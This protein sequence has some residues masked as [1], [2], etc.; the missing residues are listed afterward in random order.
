[1]L[2]DD[3]DI[4][5]AREPNVSRSPVICRWV[6]YAGLAICLAT[7]CLLFLSLRWYLTYHGPTFSFGID[8]GHFYFRYGFAA[9][10]SPGGEWTS[11]E[12]GPVLSALRHSVK[13]RMFWVTTSENWRFLIP[14]WLPSVLAAIV[15][16]M[17]FW[18]S[19]SRPP[20]G[21]CAKCGYDLTSNT[22]GICPECG[23]LIPKEIQ[24]KLITDPPK[25]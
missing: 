4:S 21:H 22:S 1:M 8:P 3:P 7:L 17:M 5:P 13:P 18:F 11:R 12:Q 24:E 14:I 25:R 19:R 23:K 20:P 9:S 6:A 16:A 15:S 10:V 2:R